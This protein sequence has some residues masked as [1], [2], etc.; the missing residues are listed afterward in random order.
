MMQSIHRP[1]RCLDA[2]GWT[3]GPPHWRWVTVPEVGRFEAMRVHKWKDLR[4]EDGKAVTGA[5]G[6]PVRIDHLSYYWFAGS[7]D[8][9]PSH[10]ERVWFDS[11]DRLLGGYVQRWAMIMVSAE[12]TAGRQ[13]FG[14]GRAGDGS[15]VLE[16][17]IAKLA[18][19]VHLETL[20]YES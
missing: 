2:Q 20:R 6:K 15:I 13:R 4:T 12:I 18:P 3:F 14:R 10:M 19:Q 16:E 17:F 8:L 11:R 9:T 5:D 1:E 7:K